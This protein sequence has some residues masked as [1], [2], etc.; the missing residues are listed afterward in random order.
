MKILS[1]SPCIRRLLITN[2]E[3]QWTKTTLLFHKLSIRCRK[4]TKAQNMK[5]LVMIAHQI[6]VESLLNSRW[7]VL[8]HQTRMIYQFPQ[9][10]LRHLKSNRADIFWTLQVMTKLQRTKRLCQKTP[11]ATQILI[12]KS[13]RSLRK[14]P[15]KRKKLF[16]NSPKPRN[17]SSI[18][19][20][21][22]SILV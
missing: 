11:A 4:P 22:F 13:K 5:S 21:P 17:I 14:K 12:G 10:L 3:R 2:L 18:K 6:I 15:K 20:R 1:Q 8:N 9:Q 16:H 19:I 7:K